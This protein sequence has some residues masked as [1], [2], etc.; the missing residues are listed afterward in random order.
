[1]N[2]TDGLDHPQQPISDEEHGVGEW[3]GQV[4]RGQRIA[5]CFQVRLQRLERVYDRRVIGDEVTAT[6]RTAWVDTEATG[7]AQVSP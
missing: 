6:R 1:V 3:I 2:F 7:G 4:R 5:A